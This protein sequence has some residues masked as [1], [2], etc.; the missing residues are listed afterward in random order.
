MSLLKA[1]KLF[2]E[3]LKQF[4]SEDVAQLINYLRLVIDDYDENPQLFVSSKRSVGPYFEVDIGSLEVTF[5][6]ELELDMRS[7]KRP[8]VSSRPDS[9][10]SFYLNDPCRLKQLMVAKDEAFD[11]IK[12]LDLSFDDPR[13]K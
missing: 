11:H 12:Q 13:T 7:E 3:F 1:K 4:S 5:S 10:S 2:Q 8:S 6:S 9:D